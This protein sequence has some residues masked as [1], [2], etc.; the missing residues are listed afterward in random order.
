VDLLVLDEAA[1]I[2]D[3][4]YY[5]IRPMLAMS[6]GRLIAATTPY[7]KRG[8]F[9]EAWTGADDLTAQ[10]MDKAT[11]EALLA[12]LGIAYITEEEWAADTRPLTWSKTFLP[13]PESPRLSKRFLANERRQVPDL[14]FRQ[15]W[16]CEFVDTMDQVFRWEDV[17]NMLTS[18]VLPLF[19]TGHHREVLDT[20][21]SS[22]VQRLF[23][24]NAN[25]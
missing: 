15:E 14:V 24:E 3:A 17:Q 1:R 21:L 8:W 20:I 9:F 6:Q 7:G 13:A 22:K 4:V 12:D 18:D 23:G 11:A 19:P 2:P 10:E 16:L 5:A 25:V